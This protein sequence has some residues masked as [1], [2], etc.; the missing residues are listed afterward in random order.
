MNF[1]RLTIGLVLSNILLACVLEPESELKQTNKQNKPTE[2][3][4]YPQSYDF[5]HPCA[6]I[7]N[8]DIS[9]IQEKIKTADVNDP[10]YASWLRFCG[11][12]YSQS[13]YTPSPVEILVRGDAKGT[14][15]DK[16]NYIVADRDFAAAMQ[17]ALRWRISSDAKYADAAVNILNAWAEKCKKITANDNN[18]YL[19]AGFQGYQLANAA[20]LLRDYS[21]WGSSDQTKFKAWLNDVWASKCRWFLETHGGNQTCSLH[22]WSNWE[23]ANAASLLAI[24]IYTENIEMINFVYENFQEGDGSMAINNMVPYAPIKDP[25]GYGMIAQSMES[26]RDQGHATLVIAMCAELCQMAWNIGIDFWGMEENK[27]LAMSEYTAKYNAKQGG[28]YVT[29]SMPFTEYK[30]CTDCACSNKSHGATHTTV[31]ADKRGSIRPCW[32]L[33]LSHYTKEKKLGV[34]D[35]YYVKIF[36]EQL[37]SIDGVLTG[38]GGA[39]DSRYGT[40]SG[41]YDT[42]GW[43]TLLF[44]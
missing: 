19:L 43:S 3:C 11:N 24:G 14:G 5:N 28:S 31:S 2:E 10:T 15:V 6:L 37:R 39:G 9:R 16:E 34:E 27:V 20:E 35:V 32:D 17:L 33:I 1:L 8:K 36:A 13:S 23:L 18:Q 41:A 30:Y 29:A 26:G 44:Y 22:Y 12:L 40:T 4:K 25:S 42:F 38:D 7:T 21:G